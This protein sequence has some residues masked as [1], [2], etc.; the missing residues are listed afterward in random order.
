MGDWATGWGSDWLASGLAISIFA[1]LKVVGLGGVVY[2]SNRGTVGRFKDMFFLSRERLGIVESVFEWLG[3]IEFAI[4]WLVV[5]VALLVV[6]F[7]P[8]PFFR[9]A[10]G[11]AIASATAT[12]WLFFNLTG[13]SL[14]LF[15]LMSLLEVNNWKSDVSSFMRR[16]TLMASGVFGITV[17]L[18]VLPPDFALL[19][20]PIRPDY[21][22]WL[23]F[24]CVGFIV[25]ENI[26]KRGATQ[27]P[28]PAQFN[29]PALLL[30]NAFKKTFSARPK[31]RSVNWTPEMNSK[32]Q[33][34]VFLVDE[35]VRGDY[36]SFKQGNQLTPEL[37][38]LSDRLTCFG[39]A[40]SGGNCSS[41][42]NVILRFGAMAERLVETAQTNPS[43]FAYA[44]KAGYRTVY[45]D[46]QSGYQSQKTGMQNF[47]TLS[48]RMEIDGFYVVETS[49][50]LK[51]ADFQLADIIAAELKGKQPVFIYANKHGAHYPYE[52]RC[53]KNEEAYEPSK[54]SKRPMLTSMISAYRNAI[55][56][57][58]QKFILYLFKVANLSNA[59][60]IYTSDHGQW[61]SPKH[62]PHGAVMNP[63][64]RTGIVPL[65]AYSSDRKIAQL[66]KDGAIKCQGRASHF[67]IAPTLYELMGYAR[68]DIA[69]IYEGSMFMGTKIIPRMS[70]GDVFGFFG[71]TPLFWDIDLTRDYFEHDAQPMIKSV[72]PLAQTQGS[73]QVLTFV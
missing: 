41:Y 53:P 38:G 56:F 51:E 73:D 22:S 19:G 14:S 49:L 71:S 52:N 7:H 57:S 18:F 43:L 37:A 5:I 48:E 32:K 69:G 68:A 61:F 45:I 2:A 50:G 55:G 24:L 13:N 4:E 34:I 20:V 54:S 27:S 70:T 42:S 6:L 64:P 72:Q 65:W 63:D 8:D 25:L 28:M 44:K 46:A 66:F 15:D 62:Y 17:F 16:Q 47:M 26:L 21:L 60:L 3:I 58:V 10:W 1:F 9:W 39:P 30:L 33:N 36:V 31:R 23:P 11:S 67:L 29:L 12:E 35:S 40:I 59:T